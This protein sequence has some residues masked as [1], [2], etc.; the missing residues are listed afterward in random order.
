MWFYD[1]L[2][3]AERGQLPHNASMYAAPIVYSIILVINARRLVDILLLEEVN[4]YD[5]LI[6]V[7]LHEF[8]PTPNSKNSYWPLF[9]KVKKAVNQT[10]VQYSQVRF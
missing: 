6:P 2:Y 10:F 8:V 5:E 7:I 3:N 1:G 9:S 4:F